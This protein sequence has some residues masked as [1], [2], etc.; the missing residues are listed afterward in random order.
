[1]RL[2]HF[3]SALAMMLLLAACGNSKE[4]RQATETRMDTLD[5]LEGT[6]SDDMINTDEVVDDATGQSGAN[7]S[8][9]TASREA[10]P[11]KP[12]APDKA[13]IEASGESQ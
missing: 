10:A 7:I 5:S 4:D 9:P 2:C 11:A 3:T 1:M 8:A 6:I 13:K 12:D